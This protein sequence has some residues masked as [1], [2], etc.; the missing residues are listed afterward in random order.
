MFDPETKQKSYQL[1]IGTKT[2]NIG[3]LNFV[4][5]RDFLEPNSIT[6]SKKNGNYYVSFNYENGLILKSQDQLIEEFSKLDEASLIEKANG[7]DRGV[8]IPLM[9]SK[10]EQFDFTDLEKQALAKCQ[11]RLKFYQKKLARQKLGSKRR[12]QTKR[13]VANLYE[14]MANIRKDFAHKT[15]HNLV[16][17]DSEIFVLEDL[18]VKNMT[19]SP[20]AKLDVDEK[21]Y[22]P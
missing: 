4:A 19:A 7:L 16:N 12:E 21:T 20:K 13:K 10:A 22:L 11:A 2:N 14:H 17:S 5:H 9:S 6:I 3:Y 8:V 15:T 18:K 1:F